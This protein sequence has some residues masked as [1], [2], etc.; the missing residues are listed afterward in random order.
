MFPMGSAVEERGE[1]RMKGPVVPL[2]E[3]LTGLSY[4]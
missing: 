2:Q 1:P 3:T 4:R